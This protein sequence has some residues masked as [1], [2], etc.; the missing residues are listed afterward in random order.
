MVWILPENI[1]KKEKE[2]RYNLS[3]PIL[4][5]HFKIFIS[6]LLLTKGHSIINICIPRAY[7]EKNNPNEKQIRFIFNLQ[8][9]NILSLSIRTC[10]I[11]GDLYI[12]VVL[13]NI[14]KRKKKL[15]RP[16]R[17]E[18]NNNVLAKF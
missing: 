10:K 3:A 1:F 13:I 7:L 15:L 18:I 5:G 2:A 8:I 17:R 9:V 14:N 6:Y 4:I 11:I 12:V 16:N